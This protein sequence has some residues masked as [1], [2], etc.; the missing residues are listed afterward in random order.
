MAR[1]WYMSMTTL[2][3]NDIN[4][5]WNEGKYDWNW[6]INGVKKMILKNDIY[7]GSNVY[8]WH[9]LFC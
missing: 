8:W 2:V 6:N 5:T 1:Q 4:E 3:I 7:W 9:I